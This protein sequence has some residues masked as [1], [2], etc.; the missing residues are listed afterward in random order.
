LARTTRP[1]L[2]IGN[3]HFTE[4]GL[5]NLFPG[6]PRGVVY[7]PVALT[8]LK[9][10]DRWRSTIRKQQGIGEDTVVIVQVSRLEA[11]KGHHL[12]LEAL[13]KL[14][15]LKTPW[16]CWMV[17]GAQRPQEEEYLRQLQRAAAN[18]G[19]RGRVQFLGQREDVPQL[20]AASDIFCQPNQAPD[21]FGIVF[22]E[23][24][25]AARPVVTTAMGGAQEIIDPSCG[26]LVEPGNVTLMAE[27]L[28][29]LIESTDLRKRLGQGGASRARQLSDPFT[30]M[31]KLIELARSVKCRRYPQL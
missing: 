12:H 14:R 5:E 18:L 7:P 25:W 1:D 29:E 8:E 31:E 19:L 16:V 9:D 22:I 23:A 15:H 3:S 24:L 27:S 2:A 28:R 20:L 10:A 26:G 4:A 13:A 11:C 6:V 17:G 30:Q 21:S